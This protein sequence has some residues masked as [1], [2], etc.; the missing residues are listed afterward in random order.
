VIF[1][2]RDTKINLHGAT[3]IYAATF[4]GIILGISLIVLV[5]TGEFP[6]GIPLIII[7]VL[8]LAALFFVGYRRLYTTDDDATDEPAETPAE[9]E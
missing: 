5:A 3:L 7:W 8:A 2:S 9:K 4:F 1:F 6:S